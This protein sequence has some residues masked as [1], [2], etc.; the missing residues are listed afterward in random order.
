MLDAFIRRRDDIKTSVFIGVHLWT[1]KFEI[2]C[3]ASLMQAYI[4]T[5]AG[6]ASITFAFIRAHL[7]IIYKTSASPRLC[8]YQMP[9]FKLVQ[10]LAFAH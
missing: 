7:R 6:I 5:R 8:G 10:I 2:A 1:K 3:N 4:I 9:K